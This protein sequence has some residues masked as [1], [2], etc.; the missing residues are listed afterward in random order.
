MAFPV[1]GCTTGFGTP[2]PGQSWKASILLA[3]IPTALVGRVEFYT[4]GPH[5]VLAPSGWSCVIS[6]AP[7]G[8]T[9]LSV[10]PPGESIAPT[11]GTQGVFATFDTTGRP[12]GAALVCPFFA[13][14]QWQQQEA[15]CDGQKPPGE[16]SSLPTPDVATVYDPAGV[17]GSLAASGGARAVGGTVIFPQ[18]T[19]A[20]SD[21]SSIDVAVESC[22]LVDT[23]LCATVLADFEVREFPIPGG[24]GGSR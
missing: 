3:P 6:T 1:V 20:V 4:D 19:P 13:I 21:G 5:A 17:S 15:D 10:E 14:P 9:D 23:S 12:A 22:A 18:V 7:D 8:A 16:F 24:L 11:P 2:P